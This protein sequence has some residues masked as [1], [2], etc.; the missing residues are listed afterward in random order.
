[1]Q[2]TDYI[3][4]A[5]DQG[6]TLFGGIH[7][8]DNIENFEIKN[9]GAVLTN[10]KLTAYSDD[11][12]HRFFTNDHADNNTRLLIIGDSYFNSYIIDDLAESF[13]ET[14]II[15]GEYLSDVQNIIDAYD[16]DIVI[17]EAAE[18]LDRTGRIIRGAAAMKES[19]AA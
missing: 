10:E 9:P 5:P 14:I 11:K 2:E 7:R 3:I 6:S 1:L 15:W 19:S 18:R 12:R 17:I 4:T 16:A 8:V 13:H